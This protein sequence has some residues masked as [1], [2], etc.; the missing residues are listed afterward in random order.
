MYHFSKCFRTLD[1][2]FQNIYQRINRDENINND[3]M[4]NDD[5]DLTTDQLCQKEYKQI[6]DT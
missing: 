4:Y 3:P 6:V 2:L 1:A 5:D